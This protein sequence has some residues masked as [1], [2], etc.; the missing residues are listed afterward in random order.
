MLEMS[1]GVATPSPKS[2]LTIRPRNFSRVADHNCYL[3]DLV[4]REPPERDLPKV[5]AGHTAISFN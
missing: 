5:A 1:L 2:I 3:L 4:V